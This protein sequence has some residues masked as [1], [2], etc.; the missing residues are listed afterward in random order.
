[1]PVESSATTG[2]FMRTFGLALLTCLG[3]GFSHLPAADDLLIADFEGETYGD[4][5]VEGEAFGPG[6]AQ[7]TLPGQMPVSGFQGQRLVNSFFQGDK[8]VGKLTSPPFRVE[9]PWINFLIGGGQH[10]DQLVVKLLVNG[11]S[12][13]TSSGPNNAPGGTEALDWDSWDVAKYQGQS[14]TIEIIDQATGGWGHINVDQIVQSETRKASLPAERTLEIAK[15]YLHLPVKTGAPKRKMRFSVGDQAVREFEIEYAEGAA[16]FVTVADVGAFQGKILKVQI[17]R[18]SGG[19][20]ALQSITNSDDKPALT[21]LYQEPLRP[22]FHFTSQRGWLNDPNGLVFAN[23]QYHLFY[24]HNPYGWNWGNMHWGHA[25]SKDL[26]HWEELPESVYPAKFGDW[27]FSGSAVVDP[28]NTT[29]SQQHDGIGRPSEWP[30]G[31][32]CCL[33][34]HGAWRV[35]VVQL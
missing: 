16:D 17:D 32:H 20:D 11:E 8:T 28:S 1:M 33:Y 26:L 12:V 34:E 29:A 19:P 30:R 15:R 22:Q 7:G 9:R 3:I 27:A 14:A 31:H 18:L 23:G 2:D 24:Q 4:W 21:E 25:V 13:R 10:Q 5:K 35:S 6:P